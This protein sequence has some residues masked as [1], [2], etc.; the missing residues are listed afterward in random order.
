MLKQQLYGVTSLSGGDGS[1]ELPVFGQQHGS[2]LG[3]VNPTCINSSEYHSRIQHC[4]L[5]RWH[6]NQPVKGKSTT[7]G[8]AVPIKRTINNSTGVT[9]GN[10][11][12][13]K[14]T[15]SC[16]PITHRTIAS[17]PN[18]FRRLVPGPASQSSRD[19]T[20]GTKLNSAQ[21][22][23]SCFMDHSR[24][25]TIFQII[26]GKTMTGPVTRPVYKWSGCNV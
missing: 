2:D 13:P 25:P 17:I 24:F 26:P 4:P 3:M 23:C 5:G 7:T 10:G 11:H 1:S 20:S 15:T 14:Y 21:P 12:G 18:T 9:A 19:F 6:L 8:Q 16:R 22:A